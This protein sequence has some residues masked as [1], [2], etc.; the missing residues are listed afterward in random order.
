MSMGKNGKGKNKQ[1]KYGQ[2]KQKQENKRFII[3]N[4]AGPVLST[5]TE[6]IIGIY[7][8]KIAIFISICLAIFFIYRLTCLLMKKKRQERD[9][10]RKKKEVSQEIK[11]KEESSQ[12]TDLCD[13]ESLEKLAKKRSDLRIDNLTACNQL[14]ENMK[15]MGLCLGVA[16]CFIG[17]MSCYYYWNTSFITS[18]TEEVIADGSM[19]AGD[20]GKDLIIKVLTNNDAAQNDDIYEE[21]EDIAFILDDPNRL[22]AVDESVFYITDAKADNVKEEVEKHLQSIYNEKRSDTLQNATP[23][24]K[25]LINDITDIDNEFDHDIEKAKEYKRKKHYMSWEDTVPHSNILEYDVIEPRKKFWNEGKYN[26]ELA[27]LLANDNQLLAKEYMAQ[28][29]N[30]ETVI[31]YYAKAI[32]WTERALSFRNLSEEDKK[33]FL[34]YLKARYKDISDY[35]ENNMDRFEGEEER[36]QEIK[37]KAYAIYRSI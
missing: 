17:G 35:I 26:Y 5:I 23:I 7:S 22:E 8:I 20:F 28:N 14:K 3:E 18:V 29:G 37:E 25:N 19:Q 15:L 36:F 31:A 4:V 10:Q 16:I 6:F 32:R 34:S 2:E 9:Y 1:N 11:R 24:E 21:I 12:D 27:F 13:E 30:P 33:T